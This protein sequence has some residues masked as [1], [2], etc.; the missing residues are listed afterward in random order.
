MSRRRI[1]SGGT[2]SERH[3]LAGM[4]WRAPRNRA[5]GGAAFSAALLQRDDRLVGAERRF[6]VALARIRLGDPELRLHCEA[7]EA[8]KRE[9]VVAAGTGGGGGKREQQA[10]KRQPSHRGT[11][12]AFW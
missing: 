11:P 8:E 10:E 7:L 5:R 9:V 6:E 2:P 12:G 4:A 3:S 1:W